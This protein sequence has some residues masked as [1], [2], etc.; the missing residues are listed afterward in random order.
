MDLP[1][2]LPQKPPIVMVDRLVQCTEL[3]AVTRF[4]VRPDNIFVHNGQLA[5][6]GLIENIAQ[7]A[8]AHAGYS[9]VLN[10]M[11]EAPA[12]YIAA[13]DHLQVFRL[14]DVDSVI[15]TAIEIKHHVLS[16]TI[17]NGTITCAGE[18]V[19]QCEMKIFIRS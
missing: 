6:P 8:A 5:E 17:I 4:S 15:E 3:G 7:T 2:L 12:G 16:V 9:N 19:A 13:V 18:P 11:Q 10:G 14:P 1:L